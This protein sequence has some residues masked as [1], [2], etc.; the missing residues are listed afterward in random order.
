MRQ[1]I[2]IYNRF[3]DLKGEL[4][5]YQSLQFGR[6]Y[7][8]IAEFELHV[9]RYIHEAQKLYKGDIIA[10]GKYTNKAAIVLTKEI[11]LDENGKATENFKLTGCTLDGLM[12]RRLTVPPIHTSHDRITA[13]AETVMKHYVEHHFVNP[14]DPK[15]KMPHIDVA[16]N[17]ERGPTI[18]WES[19]YK[20]V[21]EE[22]ES[23]SINVN[24][25]W[26]IFANFKTK[27][28][29][30][31]VFESKDLTQGNPYGNNP[32]FFS[33]EFET[34]KSQSFIDSDN[35]LKT[36]GYVGGPGE[37]TDRKIITIGNKTGWD[38]IETFIDARDVGGSEN[39]ELSPE[40]IE[41]QLVERGQSK[42]SEMETLQT[43]EGTI[44]TPSENS[45]FQY[46]QD[47]DLG[48]K[49]DV[50]N[51]SWGVKMSAPITELLEIYE[52]GGFRLEAT[53][54]RARPTLI[55]KI[56]D[57]FN[58]L[59]GIEKQELPAQIAVETKRY[60]NSELEREQQE[61]IEQAKE[62]LDASK[63]FTE[64]YAE[65]KRVESPTEPTDKSVVWVDTSDTDNIIWKIYSEE[66]GEWI[67]AASGPQGLP[68]PAG[69]DGV[70]LY[71]W[72]KYADDEDGN[73]I[74]DSPAGKAYMGI[75]YNKE[76]SVES[77]NSNDYEWSKIEGNKGDTGIQGPAGKD[78]SPRYT[79]VKYADDGQGNGFSD[80]PDGKE[81]IGLAY[82]KQT[83]AESSNPNDYT[84]S[85]IKGDKGETGA[86][87]KTSYTHIAYADDEQGNGFSQSPDGK[88]H[89]GM[90]AD[91]NS[92]SSTNPND[93]RWSLIRGR[94]GEKGVPGA[95]GDDGRTPYF[96][97][98]WANNSTGTSGF[99][100]TDSTNKIYIGTYTDFTAADSTNP[101][102]YN[103]SKIKGDPGE[104][105]DRGSQGPK[106]DT[107]SRGPQGPNI[108]DT[109]TS[110]GVNWLIADYIK[111]LNGL[112]INDQFVVGDDGNVSIG[113]DRIQFIAGGSNAGIH[114]KNGA[115]TLEDD[116]SGIKYSTTPKPN[117]IRDH[118]FEALREGDTLYN[119][120][121]R[122]A[123]TEGN[124]WYQWT[125]NKNIRIMS[126]YGTGM[127]KAYTMFG[128]KSLVT[129]SSEYV[130]QFVQ[131]KPN[132]TYTISWH[133]RKV[134]GYSAG[135]SKMR[136]RFNR[137]VGDHDYEEVRDYMDFI[138]EQ[139]NSE[140]RY[141]RFAGTFT[142]P[143]NCELLRIYPYAADSNWV[144]NDGIQLVE[145]DLPAPY[146]P[147]EAV[148][149]LMHGL[150]SAQ[151]IQTNLLTVNGNDVGGQGLLWS[152]EIYLMSGQEAIPSKKI[153]DCLNGWILCWGRYASGT[154]YHD[155]LNYTYVPKSRVTH[156]GGGGG[157]NILIGG[158][159]DNYPYRKYIYVDDD[160]LRGH[161]SN[162]SS[163]N[164]G[165]VLRY[166]Y[167]W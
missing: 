55:G 103:W 37:G 159:N 134:V 105:G 118:S 155:N 111:S 80:S 32:V 149:E 102:K 116:V 35:E 58:E 17:L 16:P 75:A 126:V 19:R 86:D 60:T 15:R 101:S 113:T 3:L 130:D 96:H 153:T 162:N 4:D 47:F 81:Y 88:T 109:N 59:E 93:Y 139:V 66:K 99:S 14:A 12:I 6:N 57:K 146:N 79:W 13:N 54:G 132:T 160:R 108:V 62:N 82:N 73:G 98:A 53:F 104:K 64:E 135:T 84:W 78:G 61:R 45:P 152:G 10:L 48:D 22:L 42:M 44:L 115:F 129:N 128:T 167:E 95:K 65:K 91:H 120:G 107:G 41:K 7:H 122:S 165:R 11:A 56:K 138:G 142:T 156:I 2:R 21:A 52:P 51:K 23:I 50:V 124:N 63:R 92:T 163:P 43:L 147:D 24:L 25:G 77:T 112:N 131:V 29:I 125:T 97:T 87:G 119:Q 72:L 70:T 49:V 18:E 28:L 8:G 141:V 1:S 39:E 83:A 90:Y 150:T 68:G 20:I 121:V 110:F 100:T 34:I 166:V 85:K 154:A 76:T 140:S 117:L 133:S 46:E 94:D 123:Y 89:I 114:I 161:S 27:K 148:T 26:G 33:P 164:N 30:F 158:A 36:V 74:S 106:G 71:T 136:V 38:R 151:H 157:L 69:K 137:F 143:S 40:E 144:M 67:A 31:D 5:N 127:A 9:N 145:G